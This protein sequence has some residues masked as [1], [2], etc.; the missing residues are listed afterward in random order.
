M[1]YSVQKDAVFCFACRHFGSVFGKA[2]VFVKVGFK[3][4][5][6]ARG[7]HGI[8]DSHSRCSVHLN[9]MQRW[10]QFQKSEKSVISSLSSHHEKV[11][12]ENR[13]YIKVLADCV[14][15]LAL[16][17]IAFRGHKEDGSS[18]QVSIMEIS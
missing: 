8:L 17:E 16:Q 4:W 18:I 2:D 9:A 14:R 11:V 3:D 13:Y 15:H 12:I 10:I 1:E 7:T 5:K 6:H